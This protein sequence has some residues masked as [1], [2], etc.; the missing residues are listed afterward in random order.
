MIVLFCFSFL[1]FLFIFK[2]G[3]TPLHTAASNGF[4]DIV[5]I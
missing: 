2:D 3:W 5:K 1:T 4:E